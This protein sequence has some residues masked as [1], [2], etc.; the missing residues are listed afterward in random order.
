MHTCAHVHAHKCT[1]KTSDAVL[2]ARDRTRLCPHGADAL[3]RE[4]RLFISKY[5]GQVV[6]NALQ[7]TQAT[8][9]SRG[10]RAGAELYSAI[11][12]EA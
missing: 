10:M 6:V 2:C 8:E 5:V 4:E 11:W 12:V 1:H 7:N 3:V 9:G